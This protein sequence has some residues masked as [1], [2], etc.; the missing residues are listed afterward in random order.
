MDDLAEK[1]QTTV[2]FAGVHGVGKTTACQRLWEPAG[3]H[4]VT[5]SSIIKAAKGDVNNTKTVTN[6]QAN[7]RLLVEG[8]AVV[9]STWRRLLIDGHFVVINRRGEAEKISVVV[10]EQLNPSVVVCLRD[11]PVA[12]LKRLSERT[13]QLP[14]INV[15]ELQDAEIAHAEWV[16]KQLGVPFC[17]VRPDELPECV[18]L[19]SVDLRD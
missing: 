11:D 1:K 13:V 8:V 3:Y 9:R 4:C 14:S 7:Q 19:L 17:C 15:A 5:A 6:I 10:F 18:R 16:S 12:I 2:F